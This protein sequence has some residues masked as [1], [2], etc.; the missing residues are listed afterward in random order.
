MNS[1]FKNALNSFGLFFLRVS[2]AAM[3]IFGHGLGKIENFETYAAK[4]ADPFG[5]GQRTSLI[6]AIVGEV[7]GPALVAFGLLTRFAASTTVVTMLVAAFYAHANDPLFTTGGPAKEMALLYLIP[8]A[9][10]MFTG[11][12]K[13][14]IDALLFREKKQMIAKV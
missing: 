2:A 6:L 9:A 10:I 3:M 11:P 12:G 1:G 5:L 14:S 7:V 13:M 8:F 4:F